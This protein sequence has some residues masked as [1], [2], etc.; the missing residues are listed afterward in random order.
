MARRTAPRRVTCTRTTVYEPFT[1]PPRN[2]C[3]LVEGTGKGGGSAKDYPGYTE[4][5]IYYWDIHAI[6]NR[7]QKSLQ[8]DGYK[9]ECSSL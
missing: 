9:E 2:C 5:Y 1:A 7:V 8:A 3:F 4:G 6:P